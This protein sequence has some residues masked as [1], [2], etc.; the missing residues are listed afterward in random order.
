MKKKHKS[1]DKLIKEI[2]GDK[3]LEPALCPECGGR[4]WLFSISCGFNPCYYE[5]ICIKCYR[6][7]DMTAKDGIVRNEKIGREELIK[8]L[9]RKVKK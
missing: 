6:E 8:R 5:Y 3:E 9:E 1:I 4:L 2:Y 7:I